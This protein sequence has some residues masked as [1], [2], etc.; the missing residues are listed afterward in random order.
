MKVDELKSNILAK[1][2]LSFYNIQLLDKIIYKL[3]QLSKI[4]IKTI[5]P[6]QAESYRGNFYGLLTELGFDEDLWLPTL[7]L[8]GYKNNLD[9]DAKTELLTFDPVD[10]ETVMNLFLLQEKKVSG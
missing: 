1:I 5:S 8:N 9:Y 3:K 4:K 7:W 6:A 10:L 2:N